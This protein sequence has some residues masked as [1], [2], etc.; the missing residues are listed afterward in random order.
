MRRRTFIAGIG[1]AAAWPMVA[2]AQQPRMPVVGRIY[3]GA[4]SE[5]D[6]NRPAWVRGLNETGFF[7]DHNVLIENRTTDGQIDRVPALVAD[8]VKG[9]V[10]LIFGNPNVAIAA[11]AATSTIPIVFA[12]SSD[13]VAIGLVASFNHPGG[14]VTGVRLRAGAETTAELVELVHELLP[15]TTTVGMIINPQF[16][17]NTGPGT[18][19]VQA[20]ITSLGLKLVVAEATEEADLG[21][22]MTKLV[23][24]GAGA[25]LIGDNAY[26]S[27]LRD[28][29]ARLGVR[30][31]LPLFGAPWFAAGTLAS[32]GADDFDS[33]RQ[34]GI[35]M[36]RILKGEKPADLPVLQ[37]TKFQLVINL[38]TA[39]ALGLIV[40][41]QILARADEVIE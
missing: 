36:G 18:A 23:E 21:P 38:K 31:R 27:S 22:A 20:T 39:K 32:Y 1:S 7:V 6:R 16:L 10:D 19:A 26:F 33:M 30:N 29:I 13:P 11:K 24:A 17:N 37:P 14:N 9:K 28:Q 3:T 34:A 25:L 4:A 12:A 40:P 2:R 35:Y 5:P 8:L 15:T 41:P